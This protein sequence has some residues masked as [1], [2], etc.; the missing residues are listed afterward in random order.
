[1]REQ[2]KSILVGTGF[3]IAA[4]FMMYP[5][6]E[7]W[8]V[9][10]TAIFTAVLYAAAGYVLS[11]PARL[12]RWYSGVLLNLPLW[13]LVVSWGIPRES[14]ILVS[15]VTALLGSYGGTLWGMRS[16]HVVRIGT[17]ESTR[18]RHGSGHKSQ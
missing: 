9:I 7:D 4:A 5:I 17:D 3:G 11:R 18:G 13:L 1:M 2:L 6:L 8:P 15:L 16:I 10:L 14:V 12:G